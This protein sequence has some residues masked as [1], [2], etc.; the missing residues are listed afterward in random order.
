LIEQLHLQFRFR[1]SE[2]DS[3]L[4]P[5]VVFSDIQL[6]GKQDNHMLR[7]KIAENHMGDHM[8]QMERRDRCREFQCMPIKQNLFTAI[9]IVP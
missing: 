8:M 5:P 3:A 6:G 1:L 4:L 9:M 2:F 7:Q